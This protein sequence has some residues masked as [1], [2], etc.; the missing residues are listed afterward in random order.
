MAND[1]KLSRSRGRN[2]EYGTVYYIQ[3]FFEKNIKPGVIWE[4]NRV[5]LS[6]AGK[7]KGDI[8]IKAGEETEILSLKESAIKFKTIQTILQEA[9]KDQIKAVCLRGHGEKYQNTMV[10]LNIDDYLRFRF[11]NFIKEA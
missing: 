7:E 6:G 10:M 5:A 11:R 9:Q 3:K 1:G 4:V 8:K 2:N